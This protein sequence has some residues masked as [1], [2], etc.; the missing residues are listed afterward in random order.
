MFPSP[1]YLLI[2]SIAQGKGS[3]LTCAKGF[4]FATV[5]RVAEYKGVSPRN[6]F[7]YVELNMGNDFDKY[8][9]NTN[10]Y[11]S[12]THFFFPTVP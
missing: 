11:I 5:T 1:R 10:K 8:A 6:R 4:S 12:L 7:F 2:P 3:V 9:M